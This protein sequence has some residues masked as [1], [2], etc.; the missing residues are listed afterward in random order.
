MYIVHVV[1]HRIN[2]TVSAVATPAQAR[3]RRPPPP[4]RRRV[5]CQPSSYIKIDV[6][7]S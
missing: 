7:K 5:Y 3:R 1:F 2:F 6:N 4:H